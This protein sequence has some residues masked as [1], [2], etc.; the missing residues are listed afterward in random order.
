MIILKII[1]KRIYIKFGNIIL[2]SRE[3]CSRQRGKV[4]DELNPLNLGIAPVF[5]E[6]AE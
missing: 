5:E 2:G 3:R 6:M 1:L 4:I